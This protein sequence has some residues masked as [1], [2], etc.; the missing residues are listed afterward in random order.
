MD[1]VI[2]IKNLQ[3]KLINL[4]QKLPGRWHS[5][6]RYYPTCSTYYKQALEQYGFVK[7]NILGMKR[8][9]RCNPFSKSSGYDPLPTKI[10]TKK[11]KKKRGKI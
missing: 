7:G 10:Q 2:D 3:I 4:Y 1:G 5:Y 8:I 9:L 6:C 11:E